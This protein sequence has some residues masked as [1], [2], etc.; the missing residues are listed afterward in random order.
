MRLNS[1]VAT[2]VAVCT[3]LVAGCRIKFREEVTNETEGDG[4]LNLPAVVCSGGHRL[5]RIDVANQTVQSYFAFRVVTEAKIDTCIGVI[6]N[7]E[8]AGITPNGTEE[9]FETTVFTN[10]TQW[11][12]DFCT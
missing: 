4:V 5:E 7:V 8:V 1:F 12:S 11:I 6:F 2:F 10:L 9:K 3:H